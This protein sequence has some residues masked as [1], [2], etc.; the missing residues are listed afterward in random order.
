MKTD[1]LILNNYIPKQYLDKKIKKNFS[2]K[3]SLIL[4]KIKKEIKDTNKTLNMLS[5][6][7]N[8]NLKFKNLKNF[9]KFK[10]ITLIG[11]GGSILG[12]EAIYAFLQGR[13]K[14]RINFINDLDPEKIKNLKKYKNFNKSLFLI[15]SKSGNTTETLSNFFSL[16]ILKKN[17]KNIIVI[18]ER[19]NNYLFNIAKKL[20]LYYIEHKPNIGGRY[21]VLSEVGMVPAYLMGLDIHKI[22]EKINQFLTGSSQSYLKDSSIKLACLLHIKKLNN[23]IFLNYSPKFEKFL[24]WCQQLIAES[25]GK[26]QKGFLPVISNAPKDH[27]SLLQLYLDGPKDKLFYIFSC[28]ENSKEKINVK[29]V[30]NTKNYLHNKS[31]SLI[32]NAQKDALIKSLNKKEIPYREF[33]IKKINEQILGKLFAYFMLETIILGKLSKINPFNQPAVEEV[34]VY[35]KNFLN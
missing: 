26:K 12:S 14:K 1:N 21:S 11:M 15:I 3:I 22:R 29:K 32:K 30:S 20:N 24:F 23:L 8:F 18:S 31:L 19:K 4:Q 6:S 17:A 16:N 35:T 5:K 9:K 33:N 10:T 27:H 2:K 34:K 25:L 7:Y 28:D 13:I